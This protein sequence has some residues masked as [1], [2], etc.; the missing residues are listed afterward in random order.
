MRATVV[1]KCI[2][3]L[4]HSTCRARDPTTRSPPLQRHIASA[5]HNNV[6]NA[7]PA[8]E[9]QLKV[10]FAEVVAEACV[11]GLAP[12][13]IPRGSDPDEFAYQLV[14]GEFRIP[15]HEGIILRLAEFTLVA[16]EACNAAA[17]VVAPFASDDWALLLN[18][19]RATV[20]RGALLAGA[21]GQL[22]NNAMG[23]C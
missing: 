4:G 22:L 6:C 3:F 20:L 17:K 16:P 5:L 11:R 18:N 8:F 14:T 15:H 23:G 12:G 19:H 7:G 10:V 1:L 9:L 13:D 2:I 21:L